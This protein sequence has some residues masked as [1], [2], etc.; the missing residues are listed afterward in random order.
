MGLG[1]DEYTP[2]SQSSVLT[3]SE[4]IISIVNWS[5]G[6]LSRKSLQLVVINI[7]SDKKADVIIDL[8]FFM[9]CIFLIVEID[10]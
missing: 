8:Y 9:S 2:A 3:L 6:A 5:S 1:I 7:K 10:A 4:K